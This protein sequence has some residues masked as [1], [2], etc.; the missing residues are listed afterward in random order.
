MLLNIKINIYIMENLGL[1]GGFEYY[2][3]FIEKDNIILKD[4][5]GQLDINLHL[6]TF[7]NNKMLLDV[8]KPLKKPITQKNKSKNNRKTKK[9][10]F[11]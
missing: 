3:N 7:K 2:K 5:D 4:Y 10:N 8:E 6:N 9:N 11:H 1:M